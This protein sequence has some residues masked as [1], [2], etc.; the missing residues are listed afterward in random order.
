MDLFID[1]DRRN[2][3]RINCISSLIIG[4][5]VSYFII[6]MVI[7]YGGQFIPILNMDDFKVGAGKIV[8]TNGLLIITEIN[9]SLII[10]L[11]AAHTGLVL[12][13]NPKAETPW[14]IKQNVLIKKNL[15]Y[16]MVL[17][18]IILIINILV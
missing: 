1:N 11:L 17:G 7:W 13:I 15:T 14:R 5:L 3:E 12:F 18:S 10:L 2:I 6:G 8:L 4:I 9:E 16:G